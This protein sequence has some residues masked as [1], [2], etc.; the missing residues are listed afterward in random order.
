ML[1]SASLESLQPLTASSLQNPWASVPAGPWTDNLLLA[2]LV[3]LAFFCLFCCGRLLSEKVRQLF[4]NALMKPSHAFLPTLLAIGT[5]AMADQIV[6]W[7]SATRCNTKIHGWLLGLYVCMWTCCIAF[8]AAGRSAAHGGSALPWY[9]LHRCVNCDATIRLVFIFTWAV[10]APFLVVWTGLG[11]YWL[12]TFFESGAECLKGSGHASM[13]FVIACL[14]ICGL[15][16]LACVIFV[17]QVWAVSHS[18]ERGNAALSAITDMDLMERWGCPKPLLEE[19]LSRGL[20]HSEI[21]L[22]PCYEARAINGECCAICLSAVSEGDRIRR[23]PCGH[24]FHRPCVDQWLLRVAS[25][26]MC[27]APVASV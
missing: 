3:T 25:C 11:W 21:M 2:Q 16:S 1:L 23:L 7:G 13:T 18:L 22:L 26:P 5:C 17:V 27:K 9:L 4:A 10:L 8:R 19:D 24:T 12:N 14:M 20:Q 15:S 6:Q